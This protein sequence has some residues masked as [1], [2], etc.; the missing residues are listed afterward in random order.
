LCDN[1]GLAPYE[2]LLI[3][4][5]LVRECLK[6]G[7]LTKEMVASNVKAGKIYWERGESDLLY[8]LQDSY[9]ADI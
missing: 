9:R 5:F 8:R 2:F 6:E 4:D 3:K 7:F 1:L